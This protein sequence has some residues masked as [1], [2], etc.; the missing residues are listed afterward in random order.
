MRKHCIYPI[1]NGIHFCKFSPFV[2]GLNC[3]GKLRDSV[4]AAL[5]SCS[6]QF[7]SVCRTFSSHISSCS[8]CF[9]FFIWFFVFSQCLS[10][11]SFQCKVLSCVSSSTEKINVLVALGNIAKCCC[12]IFLSFFLFFPQ[13]KCLENESGIARKR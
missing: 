8:N 1:E 7:T 6:L 5:C 3:D 12:V 4:L 10:I 2:L 11:R 9:I 13:P